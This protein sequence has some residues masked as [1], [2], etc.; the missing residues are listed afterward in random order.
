M[1]KA[2]ESKGFA[3]AKKL[4]GAKLRKFRLRK[5]NRGQSLGNKRISKKKHF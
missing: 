2:I 5:L 1:P 3:K 4:E